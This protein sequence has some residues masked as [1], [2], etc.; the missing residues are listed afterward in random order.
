M[1]NQ[2]YLRYKNRLRMRGKYLNR[3]GECAERIYAS[4]EKTPKVSWRILQIR[5]EMLKCEYLRK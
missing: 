4:M 5:Q 2:G 3:F 1:S